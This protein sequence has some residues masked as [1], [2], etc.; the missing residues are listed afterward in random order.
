MHFAEVLLWSCSNLVPW[1][2]WQLEAGVRLWVEF[3]L[4]QTQR[5]QCKPKGEKWDRSGHPLQKCALGLNWDANV[6]AHFTLHLHKVCGSS[7]WH[8]CLVFARSRLLPAVF[9]DTMFLSVK[10]Y[11]QVA[12]S[13]YG[14]LSLA[15]VY[16]DCSPVT[17]TRK[18]AGC[19]PANMVSYSTSKKKGKKKNLKKQ[20][21]YI[22]VQKI[23]QK[24]RYSPL[25]L[26]DFLLSHP[27]PS[28]WNKTIGPQHDF[29]RTRVIL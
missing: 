7:F 15:I 25:H 11:L 29:K 20:N 13:Y 17:M 26:P 6:G 14:E 27:L 2:E 28:V 23:I 8:N 24:D 22:L 9:I 16:L 10:N 18:Y 21:Q 3:Y 5:L 19:I 1:P 12:V 4:E